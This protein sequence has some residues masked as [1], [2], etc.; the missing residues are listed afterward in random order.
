M[1]PIEKTLKLYRSSGWHCEVQ[2]RWNHY[3]KIRQDMLGFID[4]YAMHENGR[5]LA[6]Q[7]TTLTNMAAH[8]NKILNE[9]RAKMFLKNPNNDIVLIGWETKNNKVKYREVKITR[10]MFE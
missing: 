3:A 1:S 5:T 10:E 8:H 4:I 7:V 9:P 2:E 6:I